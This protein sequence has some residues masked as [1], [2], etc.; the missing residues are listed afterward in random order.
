MIGEKLKQLRKSKGYTLQELADASKSSKSSVFEIERGTQKPS[1]Q[2]LAD[3]AKCLGVTVD[4]FL[5]E[6]DLETEV[7]Q[8]FYN[9]YLG[10][11][12]KTKEKIRAIVDCFNY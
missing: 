7:D 11:D 2:K 6:S 12:E 10:F 8:C 4:Y 1:A 3:I 9:T 5:S